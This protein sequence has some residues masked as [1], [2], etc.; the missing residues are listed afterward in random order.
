[1]L[2]WCGLAAGLQQ[3]VVALAS[4]MLALAPLALV[5]EAALVRWHWWCWPHQPRLHCWCWSCIHVC[6]CWSRVYFDVASEQQDDAELDES[7]GASGSMVLPVVHWWCGT[8]VFPGTSYT[9][10]TDFL[11]LW[12]ERFRSSLLST[13]IVAYSRL[14][15]FIRQQLTSEAVVEPE[16]LQWLQL[17]F[18]AYTQDLPSCVSTLQE[19]SHPDVACFRCMC[20]NHVYNHS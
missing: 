9:K 8:A 3:L 7:H 12:G 6:G 15:I 2:V 5:V 18:G 14:N 10:R 17:V 13:D 4:L 20:V 16:V 1:M 11:Y 19:P